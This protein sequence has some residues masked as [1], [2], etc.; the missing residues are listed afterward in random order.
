MKA[1]LNLNPGIIMETIPVKIQQIE[2]ELKRLGYWK[3]KQPQWV[4]EYSETRMITESD[5]MDWLQF[6]YLP[7]CM[8]YHVTSILVAPQAAKFW[9][10]DINKGKLLQLFIELDAII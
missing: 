4:N 7:N 3:K 10:A 6:I 9:Q 2:Q 1:N 5:F 8:Q